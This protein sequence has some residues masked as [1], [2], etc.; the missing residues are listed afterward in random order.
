MDPEKGDDTELLMGSMETASKPEAATTAD[1]KH[2]LKAFDLTA[3]GNW[4]KTRKRNI[5]AW[6]AFVN[7]SK[8]SL[9]A[10]PG[11]VAQRLVKNIDY[12]QS[13]YLFV[14][15]GLVLYCILTSPFLLIALAAAGGAA[16]IVKLRNAEHQVKIL[17]HEVTLAQQY[18]LVGL[19]CFPLFYLAGGG[20]AVF[21]II[22]AS[23]FLIMLH[24]TL[25]AIE[26]HTNALQGFDIPLETV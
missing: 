3:A 2:H 6:S 24:A 12:F 18:G 15:F 14:F 22:G 13:N 26:N 11:V 8:F 1:F 25:F 19:C 9:P 7:S 5:R 10:N 21:W 20:A 4:M 17:G 23:F 16:Y